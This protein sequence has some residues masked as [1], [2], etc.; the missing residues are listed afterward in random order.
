MGHDAGDVKDA[1][2][3]DFVEWVQARQAGLLRYGYLL[4]GEPHAAQDLVQ[5]ALAKLYL[6]WDVVQARARTAYVRR[7]MVNEQASAWRRPWRR[8][9]VTSSPLIDHIAGQLVETEGQAGHD[10]ELWSVVTSLPV[11]QRA[12]VVLRYYEQLSEAE[13]A[14]VL[15]CSIGTVKSNTHRALA[16]L[17]IRLQEVSA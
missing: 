10:A 9:E 12:A 11:K 2:D 14:D 8:R 13:T 17:R 7:I 3:A 1:A 16:A 15:G 6:K 4:T 5:T